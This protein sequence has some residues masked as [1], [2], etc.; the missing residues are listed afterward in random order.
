MRTSVSQGRCESTFTERFWP[1][2]CECSTYDG[3]MGPCAEF[4][5][6]GNGLCVYCDHL[7]ECHRLVTI[8]GLAEGR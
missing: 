8:Q 3:N 4:E 7:A 5:A 6:G 1:V 2:N